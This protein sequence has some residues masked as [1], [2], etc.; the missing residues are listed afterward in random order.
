MRSPV[1]NLPSPMC[2]AALQYARRGWPVFPCRERDE[3][4]LIGGAG[5]KERTFKAKAPYTG[6]GLKDATT[7]EQR[8]VAWW[9][10]HPAA[11]IGLPMGANGCFALDFD[12]RTDPDTGEV[13]TLERLKADLEA[14]MGCALPR[15]VT[16]M[17]QS[18]GVHVYF[19]QP[20]GEP[21][22]NRGNLPAHVDVRGLGGYL[23]A[24]PSVMVETGLRYRWLDRG[25]WRDDSA[26]AEA[27]AALVEILRAPKARAAP[28][29]E[30]PARSSPA[31]DDDIRKYGLSALDG[32]CRAIRQA[33]SGRRN[34][35]LN[36]SAL[37][38]ASLV[39]AGAID[40]AIARMSIEAAA[41]DNPGRDDDAQLLATIAS[42]WTVGFASPRDLGEIAAASRSR[43]ER[44]ST[45]SSRAPP[46][47]NSTI[48][49]QPS[50]Q[51]G[52]T[53]DGNN[54]KGVGGIS[55]ADVLHECAGLPHTDLGNLERF[56]KRYGR[57][58]L[59]VEAW[60][61]LAWDGMRWN[62]DMALALLGRAVQR[63]MREIQEEAALVKAS[64]VPFP[65]EG[66]FPVDED[67]E[68]DGDDDM[69]A[70][71]KSGQAARKRKNL[72]WFL[73]RQHARLSD[74]A[75]ERFDYIA[76][77]KSNGDVV[78]F[79]DKLGA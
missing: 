41:R 24:P 67:E 42:G 53:G 49:G 36:E 8:I 9:R 51:A 11:L 13:F 68:R 45:R 5:G 73:Q 10:D 40:A 56:L 3:T 17:T 64:G 74:N 58:F 62:R 59:Y 14:Q 26:I 1:A 48:D 23:I 60:G 33:G 37:K 16:A 54:K 75:G 35:Q 28:S 57:D 38:I 6:Q 39:A 78:L 52:G 61:W 2:S 65:P 44:G 63:T 7:D 21:I 79:S 15:S 70:R 32:E 25:D 29:A 47:P 22:K 27:P 55:G 34:A 43:R 72:L 76:T 46:D 20:G 18:D 69:F 71:S 4:R 50:S 31:G 66:G 77:I 12:P 19:R 30:R